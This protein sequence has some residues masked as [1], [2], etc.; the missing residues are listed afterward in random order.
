MS[1]V[2]CHDKRHVDLLF[3]KNII[4]SI[5]VLYD[6]HVYSPI[7]NEIFILISMKI[8]SVRSDYILSDEIKEKE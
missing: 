3:N 4:M 2:E 8:Q 7:N 6:C 5:Q 1:N